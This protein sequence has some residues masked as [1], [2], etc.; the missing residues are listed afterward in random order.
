MVFKNWTFQGD[1]SLPIVFFI[2]ESNDLKK[3]T[4]KSLDEIK[5]EKE[6][7]QKESAT[8]STTSSATT[9]APASQILNGTT[10]EGAGKDLSNI[11]KTII[12]H[13]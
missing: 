6:Q 4:V 12:R 1:S 10:P 3:V 9:P 7:R 5:R 2:L 8:T 11:G 13:V